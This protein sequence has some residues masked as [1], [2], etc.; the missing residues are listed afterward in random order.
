M[1]RFFG[2]V[3]CGVVLA[4]FEFTTDETRP[5]FPY[6]VNAALQARACRRVF[7]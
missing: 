7:F 1:V 2:V 4:R 5:P 6:Y 3:W